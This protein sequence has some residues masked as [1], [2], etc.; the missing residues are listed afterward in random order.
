MQFSKQTYSIVFVTQKWLNT[1]RDKLNEARR[2]Y[3]DVNMIA[4]YYK[5]QVVYLECLVKAL[6]VKIQ[7]SS[8]HLFF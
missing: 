5:R 2:A 8:L 4:D 1:I 6:L 3:D 7:V